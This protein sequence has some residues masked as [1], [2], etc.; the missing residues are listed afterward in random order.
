MLSKTKTLKAEMIQLL[1]LKNLRILW[2][3]EI[4]RFFAATYPA[5]VSTCSKSLVEESQHPKRQLCAIRHIPV[6]CKYI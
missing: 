3:S 1:N 2:L 5:I 6:I 4:D